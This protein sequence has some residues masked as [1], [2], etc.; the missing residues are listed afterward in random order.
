[1][2]FRFSFD[3]AIPLPVRL[4][5]PRDDEALLACNIDLMEN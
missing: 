1:M 2:M 5:R 4:S 3:K